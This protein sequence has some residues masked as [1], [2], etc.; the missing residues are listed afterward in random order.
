[1]LIGKLVPFTLNICIK[2][3]K[4][5]KHVYDDG[6]RLQAAFK[7]DTGDCVTRSVAIATQ[8]PYKQVYDTFNSHAQ[9]ERITKRRKTR[10]NA[11]TGVDTGRKW[12][13]DYM[14]SIG[15][16][17]TATMLI[18]QGCK[19]HL[20]DGELPL[21]RLLVRVSKH[22]T[23]VIDGVIHDTHDPQRDTH[24]CT[25]DTGQALR[26]G[27]WRNVNGVWSIARRC[28]YGWWSKA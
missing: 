25:P 6:G 9:S 3:S 22:Y 4:P 19:V 14:A 24:M 8:Q 28:V 21:G 18:G 11:R 23:A 2:G 16:K 10:S 13:K 5:M 27:E 17:W 7:G 12:F 26:E 1:M 15:W 20:S